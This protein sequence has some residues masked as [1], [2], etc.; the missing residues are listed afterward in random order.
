M[1][2]KKKTSKKQ[3]YS[4]RNKR[5]YCTIKQEQDALKMKQSEKTNILDIKNVI[6]VG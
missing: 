3:K 5:K 2:E 6:H 1:Y 4:Q